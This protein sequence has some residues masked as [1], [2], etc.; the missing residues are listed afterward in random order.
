MRRIW[1]SF[2]RSEHWLALI[3]VLVIIVLLITGS[4]KQPIEQTGVPVSADQI[5]AVP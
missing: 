3:I 5:E 2:L 1:Y 4:R